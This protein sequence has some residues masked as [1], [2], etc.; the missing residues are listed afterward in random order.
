MIDLIM[1][2]AKKFQG[3]ISI[4]L[5]DL[6]SGKWIIKFEEDKVYPSASLIKVP[7]MIEALCQVKEKKL[8][9]YDRIEIKK[10][11]RV[12]Y[13]IVSDLTIG[14]YSLQDLITLMII[15]SDNTATNVL[16]DILGFNEI[17]SRLE[18]LNCHHTKL[19]R[20]MLDFDMARKGKDNFTSAGDMASLME[21]IYDNSI[22]GTEYSR[23]AVDIL[24]KQKYKDK[25]GRY[26]SEDISIAHKTGELSKVSHDV[27]IFYLDN[28][29]YLIGV[30]TKD[31]DSVLGQRTIGNIS[32]II[33]EYEVK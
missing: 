13:S 21:G 25:L 30:L 12:D 10:E 14:E 11:D 8:G 32:K 7:I 1:E 27:G 28:I 16:I 31:V 23:I 3:E 19:Q 5:K 33:Y 4:V 29:H 15:V 6:K 20:K 9:L 24:L 17:N 18:V 2:E 26:I 22:L